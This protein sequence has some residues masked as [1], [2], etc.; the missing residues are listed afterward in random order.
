MFQYTIQFM[1]DLPKSSSKAAPSP[2]AKRTMLDGCATPKRAPAWEGRQEDTHDLDNELDLLRSP[3]VCD[4]CVCGATQ[5][6]QKMS[7][8]QVKLLKFM[9][10]G[11]R[12]D[13]TQLRTTVANLESL[14]L[15]LQQA[16]LQL[17]EQKH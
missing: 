16:V 14:L 7:D 17:Q 5:E 3:C 2:A 4:P 1:T 13:I 11:A 6:L 10:E 15:Q 8:L 9:L 12:R